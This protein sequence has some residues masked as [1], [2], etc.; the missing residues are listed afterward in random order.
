MFLQ[1]KSSKLTNKFQ[2]S[3]KVK[4]D[5]RHEDIKHYQPTSRT[6]KATIKL[7]NAS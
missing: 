1:S 6:E 7:A 4:H 5:P 3:S 2:L